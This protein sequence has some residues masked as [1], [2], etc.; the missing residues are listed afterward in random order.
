MYRCPCCTK[1][2]IKY[3]RNKRRAKTNTEGLSATLSA[4]SKTSKVTQSHRVVTT[5]TK[6]KGRGK[7][8]A[9][10]NETD[11]GTSWFPQKAAIAKY[12]AGRAQVRNNTY[13]QTFI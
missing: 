4:A 7:E 10:H 3:Y 8:D 9:K 5:R 2:V 1:V 12:L 11:E 6:R 13:H